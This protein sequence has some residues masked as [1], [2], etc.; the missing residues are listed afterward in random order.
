MQYRKFGKLD[1]ETSVLGFGCM[2][3]PVNEDGSIDELQSTRMLHE[4]IDGGLNYLDTAYFYHKRTSEA[5]VGR[6]LQGGY[7]DR[8]HLVTKLPVWE[9]E[10]K[11]QLDDFLNTQ[12]QKLQTD[13]LDFYLFHALA[14]K[15]WTRVLE[16]D[17]L[18]WAEKAIAD[19]RIGALGF[20][21]HDQFEVFKKIIDGYDNWAL[22]QVQYNYMDTE[23]Q[24]GRQGVQYAALK[25]IPIVVMEGLRGGKLAKNPP[26]LQAIFESAPV[27]RTP[28]GWALHWLWDQPEVKVVL[29]GMST[30]EQ[31]RENLA[32]ADE[33]KAG[34]LSLDEHAVIAQARDWLLARSPIDCTRCHYC[35]PCP[36]G[37]VIPDMLWFINDAVMY[38]DFK[39]RAFAYKNFVTPSDNAGNCVACGECEEV[40]PQNIEIIRW[41]E[42][43]HAT[44]G[45]DQPYQPLT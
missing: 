5:F 44:L 34:G 31:V 27:Q 38:D 14:E 7:R 9:L 10:S 22:A 23:Y 12:M 2:R 40:C 42:V 25:G 3:F 26:G 45:E 15:H 28:V 1:W 21:F 4:A 39:E 36:S 6:A 37:V 8:V 41:L 30:P 29:S 13:H 17:V 43:V 18:E 20:S 35:M 11:D 16:W 19:G 33:A 24:A 32:L